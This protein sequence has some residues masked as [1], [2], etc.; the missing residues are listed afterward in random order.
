MIT[1]GILHDI[2]DDTDGTLAEI[3]KRYGLRVASLVESVSEKDFPGEQP[4]E[5][6]QRRKE[7]S[8]RVLKNSDDT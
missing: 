4:S 7:E 1:A 5:T 2:V 6:W 8:L 3:E